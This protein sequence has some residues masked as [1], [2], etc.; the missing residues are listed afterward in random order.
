ML[1]DYI[2]PSVSLSVAQAAAAG[3]IDWRCPRCGGTLSDWAP[4]H[5]ANTAGRQ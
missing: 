3:A 2:D 4:D 5:L 1:C